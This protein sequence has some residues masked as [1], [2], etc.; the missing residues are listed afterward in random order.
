MDVKSAFLNG[1]LSDD[2]YM[3]QPEGFRN[4]DQ[5]EKVCKLKKSIYGLKQ[6]ARCWNEKIDA[7]LKSSGYKQSSAD[8]CIYY[9]TQVV[10]GKSVIM[11]IAVYVDDTML[12]SND[13]EVLK[14]EKKGLSDCF[15]M[16]DRGEINFILGMEVKRYREKGVM[17]IDQKLYLQNVLK[18]FGMED[19]KPVSTPV[20][21]G[22]KYVKLSDGDEPVD[23]SL[24]QA[25]IGSLNYAAIA[26]RPDLSIA[27]SMLSQFM[28][29]PGKEHWIGIKRIFRYIRG[30][31]DYGLL[32]TYSDCFRLEGYC[33]ADWAGCVET[34]KSVSG[35]IFKIGNCA[36][37]WRAKKQPIVALSS[38]EAEYVA[39]CGAAQ[40]TVWLRNLLKDIGFDQGHA[41]TLF[42]DNQ[43][44]IALSKN[45]KDHPRT[46]HIDVKYHY[47]R[48]T[49][50]K[51]VV[52]LVYCPTADMVADILTKGLPKFTF[53]KF[54]SEMGVCNV[55]A[56]SK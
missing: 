53:E 45:P 54:R 1:D 5:P 4:K 49:I 6:S 32:F 19:C 46:K 38:T 50:D 28:Q 22:K 47:V 33:D 20:E 3:K 34:R 18:R 25:A 48:E 8:P 23:I 12:L 27:V 16:D 36:I 7:Y 11:I 26:T 41:T 17:T 42:E 40:E 2:I 29:N 30:T 31:L 13:L 43:G 44:A 21:P 15:A 24:Y 14:G 56:L 52:N 55:V 9:Q 10:N 37:S 39:L 51:N 35:H